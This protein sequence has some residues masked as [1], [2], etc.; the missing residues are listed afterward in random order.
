MCAFASGTLHQQK[1]L[2]WA[3]SLREH[4][5]AAFQLKT[6]WKHRWRLS[7]TQEANPCKISRHLLSAVPSEAALRVCGLETSEI[8]DLFA[9]FS[10]LW[11][12]GQAAVTQ[13]AATS[14]WPPTLGAVG[15]HGVGH[16]TSM[17]IQGMLATTVA[18]C[19]AGYAPG[20]RA[21]QPEGKVSLP[22]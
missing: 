10:R 20:V 19:T 16:A 21:W 13:I 8:R 18:F 9:C 4:W 11:P 2:T 17:E 15:K 1:L 5:S 12:S 14:S 6:R 3:H 7:L 22:S